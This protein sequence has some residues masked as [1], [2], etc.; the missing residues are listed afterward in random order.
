MHSAIL[1]AL[2]TVDAV[3]CGYSSGSSVLIYFVYSRHF[4]VLFRIEHSHALNIF[5]F[6]YFPLLER[7]QIMISISLPMK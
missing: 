7:L 3:T 1:Y 5:Q 2:I 4:P 6:R